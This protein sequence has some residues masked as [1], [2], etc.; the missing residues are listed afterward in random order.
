M[1][2][3]ILKFFCGFLIL[4][5]SSAAPAG[6]NSRRSNRASRTVA[7]QTTSKER[8]AGW[9]SDLDA[10]IKVLREKHWRYRDCSFPDAFV[11][12]EAAIRRS[13]PQLTDD[14]V[15]VEFQSLLATL[16]DGHTLVFPFGMKRGGLSHLP[17][18]FYDFEDGPA[19]VATDPAHAFMIG[20][21]VLSIGG[22]SVANLVER[23]TPFMSLENKSQ[24]RW[25]FPTYL[26]FPAFLRAAGVVMET[27]AIA[28]SIE[29]DSGPQ[30]V[31]LNPDPA[32]IDP[33]QLVLGM[34]PPPAPT[35]APLFLSRLRD[36]YWFT[37][38][39]DDTIVYFQMNRVGNTKAEP[40][41]R[42][43]PRLLQTLL[44]PETKALI[45]DLRNNNGGN[46]ALLPPLV[47]SLVTFHGMR[48]TA[49]IYVMIGR[50]TF[51]A[52]QTLVNRL[53]E[54]VDPIF[55]GEDT[56]SKPNRFGN[57]SGFQLPYSGIIG[58]ISTGY[59]QA[60]TSRDTRAATS[61]SIRIGMKLSDWRAGR[62]VT[63]DHVLTLLGKQ[64]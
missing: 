31:T 59:N 6:Q 41:D 11:K 33:E 56:G 50:Q 40:L 1:E 52:A 38:L 45:V 12:R 21:K 10:L 15:G 36:A 24:R 63:L 29:T 2:Q 19:I 60:A 53:E 5:T 61:P 62:D 14:Q 42:F 25:V 35:V 22:V 17:V 7:T 37:T 26:T 4:A 51:S 18:A 34:I 20:R 49:P 46:G 3:N 30:T 32:P 8:N 47:R 58:E 23:A 44:R 57:G 55:V 64:H 43:S 13:I 48:P 16:N 28:V 9:T 39:S 27:N 54:Y